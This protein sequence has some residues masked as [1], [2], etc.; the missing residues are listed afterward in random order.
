MDDHDVDFVITHPEGLEP[1]PEFVGNA[2][3]IHNQEEA[4]KM[5]ILFMLKLVI[6]ILNMVT[7]NQDP[8]W[9]V[10]MDKMNLTN[11]AKFMHRFASSS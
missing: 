8:S 4:L 7:L 10:T 5:Q 11:N 6:F 3:V 9:M 2:K 1:A